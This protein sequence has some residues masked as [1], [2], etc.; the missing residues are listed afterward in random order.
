MTKHHNFRLYFDVILY[1]VNADSQ[2]GDVSFND[3][4]HLMHDDIS[5]GSDDSQ[6]ETEPLESSSSEDERRSLARLMSSGHVYRRQPASSVSD[7][8]SVDEL[9]VSD[10]PNWFVNGPFKYN[11]RVAMLALPGFLLVLL[12]SGET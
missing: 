1:F 6:F 4:M 9:N 12:F 2:Y 5:E 3:Q 8:S 11:G 10:E 7:E